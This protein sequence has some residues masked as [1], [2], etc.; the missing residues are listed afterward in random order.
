MLSSSAGWSYPVDRRMLDQVALFANM[1]ESERKLLEPLF[2]EVLC[3]AGTVIFSQESPA[4]FL[5]LLVSG[6]IV[7][8]Y[9][10]YDGPELDLTPLPAGSVFGWSA[11]MG[12]ENYTASAVCLEDC[13]ALRMRGAEL[14]RIC[15]QKPETGMVLLDTLAMSISER[16]HQSR[17]QVIALLEYGLCSPASLSEDSV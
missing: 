6:Q 3:P 1:K 14:Q 17:A 4:E 11:V 5:Y 7:L 12:S 13:K 16:Y 2:S 15:T 9:K 10:P 8:R